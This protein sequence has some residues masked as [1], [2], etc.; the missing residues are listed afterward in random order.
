MTVIN[1]GSFLDNF[2]ENLA[3][4]FAKKTKGG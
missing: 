3:K 1:G 2:A 4:R